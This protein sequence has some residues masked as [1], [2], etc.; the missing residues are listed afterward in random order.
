M[1]FGSRMMEVVGPGTQY[2]SIVAFFSLVSIGGRPRGFCPVG[3][4]SEKAIF[5]KLEDSPAPTPKPEE[6]SSNA[7][8]WFE[9]T[10]AFDCNG[11]V[12]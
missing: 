4:R 10:I 6:L 11:E 8:R 9:G 12:S 1:R 3:P 5:P 7:A 2:V